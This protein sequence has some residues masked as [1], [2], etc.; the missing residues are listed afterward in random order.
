MNTPKD[1]KDEVGN[2][3]GK[4]N[5]IENKKKE[6]PYSKIFEKSVCAKEHFTLQVRQLAI[7]VFDMFPADKFLLLFSYK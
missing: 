2:K 4:I 7:F 3:E 1:V 6:E 5:D